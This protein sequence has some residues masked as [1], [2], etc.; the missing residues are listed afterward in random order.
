MA[1]NICKQHVLTSLLEVAKLAWSNGKKVNYVMDDM[2]RILL[3]I[4]GTDF[5]NAEH[6]I[7][8]SNNANDKNILDAVLNLAEQSIS[9]GQV[10]LLDVVSILE[11]QN[12]TKSKEILKKSREEAI[13]M[14]QQQQQAEAQLKQQEMQ[15][16]AEAAQ[17][18]L[19]SA[20]TLNQRDNDTKIQVALIQKEAAMAAKQPEDKTVEHLLKA[21]EIND[22]KE[23]K[24]K[25]LRQKNDINKETLA[26]KKEID[27]ANLELAKK[28]DNKQIDTKTKLER[29]KLEHEKQ[30][31]QKQLDAD[32]KLN[33]EKIKNEQE[34]EK[35]RLAQE[36]K[37]H[38]REQ[39]TEIEKEKIKADAAVKAAKAKPKTNNE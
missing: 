26:H 8:I 4:D 15:A 36:D 16:Q 29:D 12:I 17:A 2:T 33:Q 34:A 30:M 6:G 28:T 24:D 3:D 23:L 7:F 22:N 37:Q 31:A 18:Q 21:K 19:D 39:Q 32:K 14:Q 27:K 13:Q 11:S 1:H 38:Q 9:S 10:S 35:Q 20:D 5:V 25:E